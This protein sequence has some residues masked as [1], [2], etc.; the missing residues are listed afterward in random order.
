MQLQEAAG[1][2]LSY[3]AIERQLSQHTLQAYA[4]DLA[5]FRR[6]LLSDIP[7]TEISGATLK[8]YLVEMITKRKLAAA[9]IRR[10]YACLRSLFRRIGDRERVT[11][12]FSTWRLQLPRRR[13]LPRALSRVEIELLL[14]SKRS[15]EGTLIKHDAL[16]M[17]AIRLMV[18]TGMRVGE[19][20][21]LRLDDVSPDGSSVTIH[22]KGSKERIAYIPDLSLRR[23]LSQLASDRR[24]GKERES[25]LFLNRNGFAMKPQ[26]IRSK[27]R[28]YAG[29]A[30][31]ARRVTP[32]MLR[33]TAATLLIETGVDIR[34]VQRLLGHSSIA[35]T[36]IYTH[37]SD[38]ALRSTLE[39][40]NILEAISPH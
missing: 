30:G 11:D 20:C 34:F 22:G 27:L 33:H 35:T 10:R 26:S 24:A 13:R 5:D 31:L 19:L 40:A 39:R 7:V 8:N 17:T 6:W 1:E 14:K 37:I 29:N 16:L 25:A 28:R 23:D 15:L 38:E 3:C 36:E 32:H 18:T 21:R 9:T 12:P 4:A 2:F